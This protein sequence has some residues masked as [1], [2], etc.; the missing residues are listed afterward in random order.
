MRTLAIITF[1]LV[2]AYLI[3]VT[4]IEVAAINSAPSEASKYAALSTKLEY[5]ANQAWI[6][7][8][9]LLQLII[10]LLILE[11]FARKT[12]LI[13]ST[14][15]FGLSGNIQVFIAVLVIVSYCIAVL[16]GLGSAGLKEIAL[17]VVG[18]YFGSRTNRDQTPTESDAI[19][20]P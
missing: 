4:A 14:T 12:G 16:A 6:F 13:V 1:V 8:R 18:F 17:I 10:V 2:V 20:N 19:K 11:W 7:I 3:T 5:G 15:S 9:P